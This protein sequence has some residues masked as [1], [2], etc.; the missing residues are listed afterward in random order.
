MSLLDSIV[1]KA[2]K[3]LDKDQFNKDQDALYKSIING[4]YKQR[5]T[6]DNDTLEQAANKKMPTYASSLKNDGTEL[7]EAFAVVG[8]KNGNESITT[9]AER[10]K[11]LQRIAQEQINKRSTQDWLNASKQS[12]SELRERQNALLENLKANNIK[13][14]VT[15]TGAVAEDSRKKDLEVGEKPEFENELQ[16]N[17]DNKQA[18]LDYMKT[19]K[20]KNLQAELQEKW[21]ERAY[22]LSNYETKKAIEDEQNQSAFVKL[23]MSPV[24]GGASVFS[25]T[26]GDLAT[27]NG[28]LGSYNDVF[29]QAQRENASNPLLKLGYGALTE[30]GKQAVM[31]TL[32][33]IVPGLGT[34]SY[35][36]D[37]FNDQVN[38]AIN[39]GYSEQAALN[40]GLL[41]TGAEALFEKLLG[42]GSLYYNGKK[43]F[44]EA[45]TSKFLSK[46][47]GNKTMN[48][49][50]SSVITEGSEEFLEEYLGEFN[51]QLTLNWADKGEDIDWEQIGSKET[52]QNA[53]ESGMI[54][55]ITGAYGSSLQRIYT[56]K[57]TANLNQA[58]YELERD[59][60]YISNTNRQYLETMAALAEATDTPMSSEQL[61]EN[62][63]TIRNTQSKTF[64]DSAVNL[65]SNLDENSKVLYNNL[66]NDISSLV[67]DTGVDLR[68]DSSLNTLTEWDGDTLK[69]NPTKTDMPIKTVLLKELSNKILDNKT[70]SSILLYAKETG[71][72]DALKEELLAS[73][74]FDEANVDNEIVARELNDVLTNSKELEKLAKENKEDIGVLKGIVNSIADKLNGRTT[75]DA[76]YLK[77]SAKV[78]NVLNLKEDLSTTELDTKAT[79]EVEQKTQNQIEKVEIPE[80]NTK[81]EEVN[82]AT[83]LM[84][85]AKLKPEDASTTPELKERKYN[86][87]GDGESKQVETLQKSQ[88]FTE[89]QKQKIIKEEEFSKYDKITNKDSLDKAFKKLEKGGAEETIRW[90][91]KKADVA[92]ATDIAEGIILMKQYADSKNY[93]GMIAIANKLRQMKTITA[94]ALQASSIMSRMT[95]E[96]MVAYAQS[97]LT[98]AYNRLV[99]KK[100]QNWI[101]QHQADF[102]LTTDEVDFIMDTMKKVVGMEDGYEKK[103][104]LAKI[105]KLMNDKIPSSASKALKGWM[106]LSMLFNP[107]T[108]VRN[109]AGNT[110]IAP[111]NITGDIIA[112]MADKIVAKKT[113]VRTTGNFNI[114]EYLKGVKRGAYE[115]TNDYKLGINTKDINDRFE[116]GEGKSFND[117]TLI[118]RGLNRT[119]SLLNYLMD[120]GDRVFSE[121]WFENSLAN[122]MR[123]N[124]VTEPT[125]EMIDIALN[126]SLQRTWN[127]N[128]NYTKFVLDVRRMLNNLGGENY[129]LGDV[130][131][132][133][134]KTPANLTK[135]IVDFS[136]FG[137]VN[138][139][140]QYNNLNKAIGKGEFTPQQQHK[141]VQTLGKATAG[142]MLYI[143]GYAL[144][145]SGVITG[146]DDEDKDTKNF[147][148]NVLGVNQYS[149][150]IGD[151]SFTYDWAQPIAA[152]L[153]IMSNIV[154]SKDKGTGLFEGIVSSLDSANAILL[155][156]S[157]LQSINDVLTD[158]EGVASG[159]INAILD[160]PA[161]AVPTFSK[162]IADMV[163]GTQRQTYEKDRP[164]QTAANKFIAKIPFASK[165]LAPKVNTMGE[166]VLKYGGNNNILNVMFNPA[167]VSKSE[168]SKAGQEIYRVY[169][170]TNDT[171]VMPTTAPYSAGKGDSKRTLTSEEIARFQ[172]ISGKSIEKAMN[173]I[174]KSDK[175]KNASDTEKAEIIK[176]IVSYST[177]LAKSKVA[178]QTMAKTYNNVKEYINNGGNLGDYY[179]NKKEIDYSL[180]Y[181]EKYKVISQIAPYEKYK[182]YDDEIDKIKN[183]TKNE[184]DKSAV[185]RYV[186]NLD[187]SLPQKAMLIKMNYKSFD[188]YNND[189]INY[190]D[191]NVSDMT[192]KVEILEKL[193]FKVN[194]G[195]VRW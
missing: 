105:Q 185:I 180:N 61:L 171:S 33:Q 84:D 51:K 116:A 139:L 71:V 159:L 191:Q 4:N 157:F 44:F 37:I 11:E 134:A 46:W 56:P 176:D 57:S 193:G 132:P 73:G 106:R 195:T 13:A 149:V 74:E 164:L 22:N 120:V 135:A 23:A 88:L 35:F 53:I 90:M 186:S 192:D 85:I 21:D 29:M 47:I 136:P 10:N 151:K 63:Y 103:V 189:I 48:D 190:I 12:E 163:D 123:L 115:A 107:K 150:K 18:L 82:K 64:K 128:N 100:T 54:G 49:V 145:K 179:L 168:V 99:K 117:K 143:L 182:E 42:A 146:K 75:K 121:G 98:E 40:Y 110:L 92:D 156:Q 45:G 68:F 177:A 161:R 162:Q 17:V 3:S 15:A 24:R 30:I 55:A 1:K 154:N 165:T 26:R 32:N 9:V 69:L 124:N 20:Y 5:E 126:E 59:N 41:S 104:E 39:N 43:G 80:N 60:G 172:K 140:V 81:S 83:N 160:L 27:S 62:L 142:S 72:Y 52:L 181:P 178:G 108:Q 78:F 97:E 16:K 166:D 77:E 148:K 94:Q 114:K 188:T 111:A 119:E 87:K 38:E 194:N 167:N 112:S 8:D 158:N 175:Y 95:P 70:K 7:G 86:K 155:E 113:G 183:S 187:L 96:G 173:T 125:Q 153:A 101:D 184:Y 138:S 6:F 147:I 152:P 65:F 50:L 91:N 25:W 79:E 122:Q 109:V 58:I 130:L 141:F 118:G 67:F 169:K 144:A 93:E 31:Q 127:D 89:E 66:V 36:G 131:I 102:Q 129:G 137:L 19:D 28:Q 133:F 174:M 34:V 170:A 76:T 14:K 2:K